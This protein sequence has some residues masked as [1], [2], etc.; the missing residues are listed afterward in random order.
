MAGLYLQRLKEA[1][2]VVLEESGHE[3]WKPEYIQ[4]LKDFLVSIDEA[5][6]A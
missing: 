2:V 5:P 4:A 6:R 3:L 1:R